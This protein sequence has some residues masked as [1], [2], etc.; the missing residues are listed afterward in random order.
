MEEGG[1]SGHVVIGVSVFREK[2]CGKIL[3]AGIDTRG[4]DGRDEGTNDD[5]ICVVR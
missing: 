1:G 4:Q 5:H 3:R 2:I